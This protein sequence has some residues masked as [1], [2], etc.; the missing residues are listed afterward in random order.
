M[1]RP[2]ASRDLN[3]IEDVSMIAGIITIYC[4]IFFI[5]N[6]DPASPYYD[7]A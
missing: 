5:T 4:G 6:K 2:F 3:D 1:R 7:S